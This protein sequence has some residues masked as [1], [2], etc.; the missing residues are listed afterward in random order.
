MAGT[1]QIEP[2]SQL[3]DELYYHGKDVFVKEA[4][5]LLEFQ[6]ESHIVNVRDFLSRMEP[7]ISLWSMCRVLH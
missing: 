5:I 3:K 2:N 6:R 4:N 1:N 7:P